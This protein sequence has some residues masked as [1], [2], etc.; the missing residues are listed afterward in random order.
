MLVAGPHL[1]TNAGCRAAP[2]YQCW[3]QGISLLPMLVAGP[4][5]ITNAVCRAAPYYLCWLQGHT[6]LPMLFAGPHL[7]TNAGC[8]SSPYYQCWLQGLTLTDL[9]DLLEDITVYT[10]MEQGRNADYWR[11]ITIV[12]EDECEKLRKLDMTSRGQLLALIRNRW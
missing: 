2:Y 8:M 4:H 9:E 12:T 6:L 1:I 7:I 5:L 11:D 10:E 3:L